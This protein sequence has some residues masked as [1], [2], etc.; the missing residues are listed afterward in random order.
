MCP[1]LAS[2]GPYLLVAK[3]QGTGRVLYRLAVYDGL[4]IGFHIQIQ[5]TSTS[6]LGLCFYGPL[7][8]Y[9]S[10]VPI[11]WASVVIPLSVA[12]EILFESQI[13]VESQIFKSLTCIQSSTE[14]N[15]W[16]VYL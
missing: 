13:W 5:Y 15:L 12:P 7:S 2:P 14:I 4:H 3:S 6:I 11:L 8:E 10:G 9:T 16:L 1:W